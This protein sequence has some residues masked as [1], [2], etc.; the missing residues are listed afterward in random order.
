[1]DVTETTIAPA[2]TNEVSAS[3][4]LRLLAE[5]CEDWGKGEGDFRWYGRHNGRCNFVEGDFANNRITCYVTRCKNLNNSNKLKVMYRLI[6]TYEGQEYTTYVEMAILDKEV[7]GNEPEVNN[8]TKTLDGW[9][10]PGVSTFYFNYAV[11]W[12]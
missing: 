7:L 11:Q 9:L 4:L 1:M 6:Q 10:K 3:G 12:I 5:L 8:R 2:K